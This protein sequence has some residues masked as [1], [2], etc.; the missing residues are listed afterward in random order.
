MHTLGSP[1]PARS[2]RPRR[3]AAALVAGCSLAVAAAAALPAFA[4]N[5][6]APKAGD[7]VA[8]GCAIGDD[9][10]VVSGDAGTVAPAPAGKAVTGTVTAVDGEDITGAIPME[11]EAIPLAP[12]KGNAWKAGPGARPAKGGKVLVA[13]A[14]MG[15]DGKVTV[16]SG[17]GSFTA[18]TG[19]PQFSG[20]AV[21]AGAAGTGT[22]VAV[23]PEDG[24]AIAVELADLP[25]CG[26]AAK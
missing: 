8:I 1:S 20:K 21:P 13:T 15:P 19:R 9:G 4:G 22:G 2:R 12:A 23:T 18:P 24:Q 11:V 17:G 16:T 25:D 7:V 3:R 14:T 6:P 10:T 26:A 5:D